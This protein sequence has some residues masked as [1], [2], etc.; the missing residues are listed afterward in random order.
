M[1]PLS[2]ERNIFIAYRYL[3]RPYQS[4]INGMMPYIWIVFL[5][6]SSSIIALTQ[7]AEVFDE[8]LHGGF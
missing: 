7:Y 2:L 1:V 4:L 5:I 6:L 8:Y 3:S